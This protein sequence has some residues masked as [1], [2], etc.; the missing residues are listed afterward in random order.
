MEVDVTV[1]VEDAVV[2]VDADEVEDVAG[3]EAVAVVVDVDVTVTVVEAVLDA[4]ADVVGALDAVE[5]AV[6]VGVAVEVEATV[7]VVVEVEATVVVAVEV[8][9]TVGAAVDVDVVVA[10]DVVVVEPEPRG[11]RSRRHHERRASL[12]CVAGWVTRPGCRGATRR[13]CRVTVRDD[14]ACVSASAPAGTAR[15]QAAIATSASPRP[16]RRR[17]PPP[18]DG[19]RPASRAALRT[20]MSAVVGSGS[21]LCTPRAPGL[22]GRCCEAVRG[23]RAAASYSVSSAAL[24]VGLGRIAA[25]VR[26]ASGR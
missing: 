14:A 16:A 22:D 8:E 3:S 12:V 26:S 23:P 6:E 25:A 24:N 10:V 18:G 5:V 1:G 9:V 2:E 11:W 15:A 4:D 13:C 7:V 21:R 20:A 19:A 17:R